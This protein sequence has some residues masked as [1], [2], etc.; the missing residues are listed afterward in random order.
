MKVARQPGKILASIGG[1]SIDRE[2]TGRGRPKE[3]SPNDGRA[4]W[5]PDQPEQERQVPEMN[6]S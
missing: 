1:H 2:K 3:Q 5:K 6:T 4:S